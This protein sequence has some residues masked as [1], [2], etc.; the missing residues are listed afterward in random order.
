MKIAAHEP[1]C[2]DAFDNNCPERKSCARWVYRYHNSTMDTQWLN[3]AQCRTD[4]GCAH[5]MR[6]ETSNADR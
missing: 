2:Q 4:D 6:L 1:R 3:F 5:M